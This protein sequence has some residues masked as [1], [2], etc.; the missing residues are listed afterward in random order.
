MMTKHLQDATNDESVLIISTISR[1]SGQNFSNFIISQ[2][3]KFPHV[4][5]LKLDINVHN[6]VKS[7]NTQGNLNCPVTNTP[8][9]T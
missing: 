1:P 5:N 2:L 4:N 7:W 3:L 6:V 9:N 8:E